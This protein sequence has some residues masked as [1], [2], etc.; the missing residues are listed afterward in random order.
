LL[1]LRDGYIRI[2]EEARAFPWPRWKWARKASLKISLVGLSG[3]DGVISELRLRGGNLSYRDLAAAINEAPCNL[4]HGLTISH[5]T[6]RRME[7]E[8]DTAQGLVN[9]KP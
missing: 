6:L 8:K 4:E 7:K 5:D 3:L 2:K 1:F 9:A